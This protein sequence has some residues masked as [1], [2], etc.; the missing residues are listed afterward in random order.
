MKI[1]IV[2]YGASNI[3]NVANALKYI[4]QNF[5]V[6]SDPSLLMQ[7]DKLI[8]PGVGAASF[9]MRTLRDADLAYAVANYQRP[10][11]GICLGMQILFDY[12]SEGNVECLRV[13]PGD[14]RKF[15]AGVKVP[16]IG[17]NEIE[18]LR[19]SPLF[20]GLE[21]GDSFYFVN[22]YYAPMDSQFTLAQSFYGN[23]FAAAVSR[24]NFYGVQFHPEKSGEKGLNLLSN[25]CEKC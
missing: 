12:S 23:A 11:L 3:Q 2:D 19:N 24:S 8:L 9:A 4:G 16:Q 10:V 21:S 5:E 18:I 22:S 7:F 17:W 25:F 15:D 14:V 6:I 1:A 13:I 20:D